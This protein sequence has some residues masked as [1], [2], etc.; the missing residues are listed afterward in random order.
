[1]LHITP[2]VSF[3]KKLVV[4]IQADSTEEL[5][6]AANKVGV[7]VRDPGSDTEHITVTPLQS[8]DLAKEF[9]YTQLES[10]IFT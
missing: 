10:D 4:H 6:R 9:K 1:V 8:I 5:I 2:V 7:G 3:G